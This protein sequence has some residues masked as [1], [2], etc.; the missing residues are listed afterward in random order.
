[1]AARWNSS[2]APVSPRRPSQTLAEP[3]IPGLEVHAFNVD[4]FEAATLKAHPEE[5]SKNALKAMVNLQVREAHLYFWAPIC[6]RLAG[7]RKRST[8]KVS[9]LRLSPQKLLK[10]SEV[11]PKSS[12]KN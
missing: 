10:T 9:P 2:R 3:A 4:T 1:M 11:K 6:A 7:S 5:E 8:S 12:S